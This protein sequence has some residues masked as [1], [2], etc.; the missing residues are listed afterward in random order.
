MDFGQLKTLGRTFVSEAKKGTVDDTEL[1][2]I[3]NAGKTDV[4]A[5]L[6]CLKKN[7]KFASEEDVDTYNLTSILTRYLVPDK[8]GLWYRTSTSTNYRP[9]TARTIKWLDENRPDW[10]DADSGDPTDYAIDGD[11]LIVSPAPSSV[12]TDAFWFYYGSDGAD[13]TEDTQYPFGGTTEIHRL[14]IAHMAIVKYTEWGLSKAVHEGADSYRLKENEYLR[15]V[16][17]VRKMLNRRKD[18]SSSRETKMRFG[19]NNG[20]Y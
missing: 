20:S 6:I 15:E 14:K 10:R 2:A 16:E 11:N 13:M 19:G 17:N 1:E 5:Q 8:S 7:T 3:I 12:I 18:L 4:A 9:L